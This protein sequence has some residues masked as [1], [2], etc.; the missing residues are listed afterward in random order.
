MTSM[1]DGPEVPIKVCAYP[2]GEDEGEHDHA[3]CEDVAAEMANQ[4]EA[5]CP[6]CFETF[7]GLPRTDPL[8]HH[9]DYCPARPEGEE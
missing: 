6:Y 9:V 3:M 5:A 4:A 7:Y 1:Y 8:K 2:N